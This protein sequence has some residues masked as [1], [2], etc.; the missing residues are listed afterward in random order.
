MR[1]R[2]EKSVVYRD[3]VIDGVTYG[4]SEVKELLQRVESLTASGEEMGKV[5]TSLNRQIGGFKTSNASYKKQVSDRD[6]AISLQKN[7]YDKQIAAL[8]KKLEKENDYSKEGNE[9]NEKRIAEIESLNKQIDKFVLQVSD[10]TDAVDQLKKDRKVISESLNQVYGE[11][12][13]YKANYE[14]VLSLPWYKRIFLK[15]D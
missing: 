12:D 6:R 1:E 2:K 8:Q 7:E 13:Q 14:H 3:I 9:I 11:R 10:L 4:E 5:I 15:K